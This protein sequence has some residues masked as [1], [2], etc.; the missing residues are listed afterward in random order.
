MNG[1]LVPL[2]SSLDNGDTV[3]VFTS[4]SET[5][6]PSRDWLTFVRSPRARSKI[7]QHFA[8]ERRD[9][10]VEEG[11]T[12]LTRAVRKA[13]L[14]LQRLLSGAVLNDMARD[15]SYADVDA[16]YAAVGEGHVPAAA[17]VRRLVAAH[18]DA[19][20]VVEELA[21][22]GP[23][24]Q[25]PPRRRSALTAE[26][27]LVVDGLDGDVAVRLSRCCTPVP[28]DTVVGYVT[29]GR[30]V[31]AHRED[32]RNLTEVLAAEPGRR[33]PVE[34]APAA[35]STF[36]VAVKVEALDRQGL[37]ADVTRA[38]AESHVNILSADLTTGRDVS[39]GQPLHLRGRQHRAPRPPAARDPPG[40]R[41]LRRLP[42]HRRELR[43]RRRRHGSGRAR[44]RAGVPAGV[45]RGAVPAIR[46][47]S[48]GGR[49]PS[50][51]ITG[52]S[53]GPRVALAGDHGRVRG[54]SGRPRRGSRAGPGA[55]G[56]P[57]ARSRVGPGC[58]GRSG[59]RREPPVIVG[60]GAGS[61]P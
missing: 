34:W 39:G 45:R 50:P 35:G 10:A 57:P 59:S 37:L 30:G 58:L 12:A 14:P 41:G 56:S 48:G 1:R 46:G 55:L 21:E 6:R 47:G 9:D 52:G 7:R 24:R 44:R 23:V 17:V 18:G 38:L 53:G 43:R 3:E 22:A 32:C 42:R 28:G 31:S 33:V 2:E 49:S 26:A 60:R 19:E 16:L 25:A 61:R 36:L 11:K 54:S 27:G 20:A 8:K 15:M 4:R 13:G 5:A 51:G 40:R 29:R